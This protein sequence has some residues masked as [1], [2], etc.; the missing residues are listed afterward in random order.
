MKITQE[1]HKDEKGKPIFE[2]GKIR[3]ALFIMENNNG[4]VCISDDNAGVLIVVN[5]AGKVRF[6]YDGKPA[7]ENNQFSPRNIVTDSL[8]YII[9][10]DN[11]NSCLHIIDQDGQFLTCVDNC[12]VDNVHA[13]SVDDEGRLW[14]GLLKSGEIKVKQY[15]E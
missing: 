6:R 5:L 7:R 1:I 10:A 15:L 13:L 12:E 4:D 8:N 9:V 14:A 11:R 2:E 3:H